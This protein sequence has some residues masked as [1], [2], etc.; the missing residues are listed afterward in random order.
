MPPTCI[1]IT[2]VQTRFFALAPH[3]YAGHCSATRSGAGDGT[4]GWMHVSGAIE[5]NSTTRPSPDSEPMEPLH[6]IVLKAHN[7][8]DR[9][10]SLKPGALRFL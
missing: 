2:K 5:L 7:L 9:I 3:W 4:V 1:N 10:M 6:S 8:V